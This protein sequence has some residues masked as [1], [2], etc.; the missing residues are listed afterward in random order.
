MLLQITSIIEII[1]LISLTQNKH[2]Y[3]I[4]LQFYF[5]M[6]IYYYYNN[7]YLLEMQYLK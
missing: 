6:S 4:K 3:N 1:P 2:S 7:K 5:N